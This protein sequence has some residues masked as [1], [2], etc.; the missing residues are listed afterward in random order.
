MKKKFKNFI[1]GLKQ[2][3]SQ[4]KSHGIDDNVGLSNENEEIAEPVAFDELNLHPFIQSY[5][6]DIADY[7]YKIN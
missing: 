3:E 1:N 7:D 6:A 5:S 2:L 4:V